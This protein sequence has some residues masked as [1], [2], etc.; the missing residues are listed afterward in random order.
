MR[1]YIIIGLFLA[2]NIAFAAYNPPP[3]T[4]PKMVQVPEA[5]ANMSL[6]ILG[7][8][9]PAAPAGNTITHEADY[10]AQGTGTTATP[11]STITLAVGDLVV[12]HVTHDD[13]STTVT[14]ADDA[15]TPNTYTAVGTVS[16]NS[17]SRYN[18]LYYSVITTAKAGAAITA[19]FSDLQCENCIKM[20]AMHFSKSGGTWASDTGNYAQDYAAVVTSATATTSDAYGLLIVTGTD[21]GGASKTLTV[22]G[23]TPTSN[24]NESSDLAE[25]AW[26]IAQQTYTDCT[27]VATRTGDAWIE[28]QWWAIG[29]Q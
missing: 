12:V 28:T 6:G 20:G 10:W 25:T 3:S 26:F 23:E 18:R 27:S 21:S 9:V 17:N 24:V 5:V 4:F 22:C 8:S 13:A 7:G 19:T 2:V 15:D 1:K 11:G 16:G 29:L 14:V